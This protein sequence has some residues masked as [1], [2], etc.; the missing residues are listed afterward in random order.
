MKISI[1]S[2]RLVLEK[3]NELNLDQGN[4]MENVKIFRGKILVDLM[5]GKLLTDMS[6]PNLGEFFHDMIKILEIEER[7][8]LKI[9]SKKSVE[10]EIDSSSRHGIAP[11]EDSC[12]KEYG[13]KYAPIR[14]LDDAHEP[15]DEE[16]DQATPSR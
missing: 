9:K 11:L 3:I 4:S 7:K 16:M 14:L 6:N 8:I 5:I 12:A 15:W 10:F 1:S 13:Y 2:V